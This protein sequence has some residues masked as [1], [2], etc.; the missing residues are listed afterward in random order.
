MS[1]TG[2]YSHRGHFRRHSGFFK[3]YDAA[4]WPSFFEDETITHGRLRHAS[5]WDHHKPET[6]E[7]V[8][9]FSSG[10]RALWPGDDG[11]CTRRRKVL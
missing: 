7:A 1:K 3:I 9:A 6:D 2:R 11:H 8:D 10:D 4:G 5:E